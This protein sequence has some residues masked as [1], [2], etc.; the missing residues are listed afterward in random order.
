MEV[1]IS[2]PYSYYSY[3]VFATK[4]LLRT[5]DGGPHKTIF[6]GNFEILSLM[7]AITCFFFKFT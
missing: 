5:P 4:V 3:Y 6:W 1:K 2:K 7:K